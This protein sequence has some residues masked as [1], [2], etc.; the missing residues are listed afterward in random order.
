MTTNTNQVLAN[1]INDIH[2]SRVE[3]GDV[4]EVRSLKEWESTGDAFYTGSIENREVLVY[5]CEVASEVIIIPTPDQLRVA[6]FYDVKV[7][8]QTVVTLVLYFE[9]ESELGM[10]EAI[11]VEYI[12]DE[13]VLV[14]VSTQKKATLINVCPKTDS[15]FTFED[16]GY[17]K[18]FPFGLRP[19]PLNYHVNLRSVGNGVRY[20]D[21]CFEFE[22]DMLMNFTQG[23]PVFMNGICNTMELEIKLAPDGTLMGVELWKRTPFGIV[24]VSY[25]VHVHVSPKDCGILG[26]L[27]EDG[28]ET[29]EPLEWEDIAP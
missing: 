25:R 29:G 27:D 4:M 20:C 18:V 26:E 11:K 5:S 24:S 14:V 9:D 13:D 6:P 8:P 21:G 15:P 3:D 19:K 2:I 1:V 10:A 28:N 16:N 17:M 7:I 23:V 22:L 12:G